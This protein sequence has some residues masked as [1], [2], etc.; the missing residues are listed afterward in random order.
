MYN[1]KTVKIDEFK[2]LKILK[3]ENKILKKENDFLKNKIKDLS[4]TLI[5]MCSMS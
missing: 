3:K 1:L 2:E 5:H 4:N